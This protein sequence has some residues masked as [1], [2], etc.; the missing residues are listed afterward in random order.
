M[1]FDADKSGADLCPEVGQ[2]VTL[3]YVSQNVGDR[4]I[5]N[6][7]AKL[8]DETKIYSSLRIDKNN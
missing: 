4:H 8:M 5:L 3:V 6:H 7:V 1:M 2:T